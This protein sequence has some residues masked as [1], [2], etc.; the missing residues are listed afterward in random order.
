M[1]LLGLKPE[2]EI[3]VIEVGANHPLEHEQLAIIRRHICI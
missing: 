3:A 1:T 2:H